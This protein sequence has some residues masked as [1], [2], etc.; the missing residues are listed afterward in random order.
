MARKAI[1]DTYYTFTPSTRTLVIPRAIPRERLILITDV[2]T[3][4]VLYNF[5]DPSLTTTSYV[6]ATSADGSTTT[7]TITLGYNTTTLSATDKLQIIVD[8][9]DEKFSPSENYLDPVN[10]LRVS[11]P[12]SLIDTDFEYSTQ[13]TKWEQLAMTNNRPF[14]HY[15]TATGGFNLSDITAI[16]GSRTYTGNVFPLTVTNTNFALGNAVTILDTTYAG[17]DGTYVI[18]SNPGTHTF[19]YTGKYFFTR[20]TGSI[21]DG[22]T[23]LAY[24]SNIYSNSAIGITGIT[25]TGNL[26]NVVT[27]IPHGLSLG[28]EIGL[29]G[30]A[31]TSF[32]PNGSWVVSTVS[33]SI[34]FSFYT[35]VAPTGTITTGSASLYARPLGQTLHRSL[36]AGIRFS[37]NSVSHNEQ[38]I[39][40]TRRYFR[41]QSGK[42]IQMSTGTTLKSNFVMDILTS[43]GTTVTVRTKDQHNINQPGVGITIYGANESAYN[44]NFVVTSVLDPYSFT[45]TAASVPTAT[46][47]SG[48]YSGAM[49]FWYGSLVR[50]GLFDNQNGMFFE[51]NGQTM[52]AVRRSS[53]GPLSGDV[54]VAVGSATVIGSNTAFS[55]QL[56]PGDFVVIRGMSYRVLNI[57]SDA[58]M[59]ISPQYRGLVNITNSYISKTVDTRIPQSEWNI[60]RCDGT[61]PSGFK[62]DFA[63]MQMFY[64]DYSWYGAG[65]IRWGF[66]G[67]NGDII[68]CH[69]M[70]NNNVNQVAY[71]RS[72]NLPGRYETNSFANTAIL[73]SNISATDTT[74]TLNTIPTDWPPT[75]TLALR[76]TFNHEFV[77][78]TALNRATNTVT[79]SSRGSPGVTQTSTYTAN[80]STITT[81][82]TVNIQPG[83]NVIGPGIPLQAYVY[84]VT[85]NSSVVLTSAPTASN[86]Q[87]LIFVPMGAPAVAW[88]ANTQAPVAVEN[89]N[90]QFAAEINHWGTSAIMDGGFDDDKAFVFTSGMTNF[91]NIFAGRSAAIMSLRSSPCASGGIAGSFIGAREIVNRM[92]MIPRSMGVYSNGSLLIQLF[93]N[94]TVSNSSPGWTNVGG[95]SLAQFQFH[96]NN[97]TVSGGEQIYAFYTETAA[98]SIATGPG[99]APLYNVTS[100][101]LNEIRDLGTSILGGG[102]TSGNVAV[103]PDGPEVLTVVATNLSTQGLANCVARISWTEA[104][105]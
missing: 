77:A 64:I 40:Q 105:A 4:Q 42:G 3:N 101:A 95:S 83:M 80:V 98:S 62:Q 56:T 6:I 53:T 27:S 38:Y 103:Y 79:V 90:P 20:P 65:F 35:T 75:G 2:T 69:R 19:N 30:T 33:N 99:P 21:L 100:Q 58:L 11:T 7:T 70:V 85:A 57:Q 78:Y 50:T 73:A 91:A 45:Y 94:A 16:N 67:P 32:A 97:T 92:Q 68:Y 26:V 72:G 59:T 51:Y 18:D 104:Q 8:E 74:L 10:K 17:A 55:K 47:A 41:Y 34:A 60:D 71:M 39:R 5:S 89:H 29:V 87:P 76:N 44:G 15:S 96:G 43:S 36:Q 28:N 81:A 49:N 46:Q 54:S 1:I 37:H 61:G 14:A 22:N 23:T 48:L 86:T 82:N 24:F 88:T 12:T 25:N 13:Q 63:K 9:Y 102:Q 31:A 52:T 84:S 93:L 66:R